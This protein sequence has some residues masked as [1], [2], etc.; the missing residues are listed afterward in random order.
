M[1][2]GLDFFM[3]FN[4][5]VMSQKCWQSFALHD[6]RCCL[7]EVQPPPRR[8]ELGWSQPFAQWF[9]GKSA[10]S[11]E[12]SPLSLRTSWGSSCWWRGDGNSVLPHLTDGCEWQDGNGG[13]ILR[14]S[15][16]DVE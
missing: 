5:Y 15:T 4:I 6:L 7:S 8:S 1:C 10:L 3:Y 2:K 14:G 13:L 16:C 11:Q 9:I 12:P